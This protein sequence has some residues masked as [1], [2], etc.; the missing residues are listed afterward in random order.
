MREINYQGI[1]FCQGGLSIGGPQTTVI[2]T[3]SF[4]SSYFKHLIRNPCPLSWCSDLFQNLMLGVWFYLSLFLSPPKV[5]QPPAHPWRAAFSTPAS[6]GGQGGDGEGT[7]RS[8]HP[9][10]GV[11]MPA[12]P[13]TYL[14][15]RLWSVDG[16]S[17]LP[18]CCHEDLTGWGPNTPQS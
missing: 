2:T 1:C 18:W 12:L 3:A 9:S 7:V 17:D 4:T 10:S 6:R 14:W 16:S 15:P 8:S 5:A 11:G 13:L